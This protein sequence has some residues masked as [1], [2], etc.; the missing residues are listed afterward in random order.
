MEYRTKTN[1]KKISNEESQVA[2]KHLKK[3]SSSLIIGKMQIKTSLR[4]YLTIV[5]MAKIENSGHRRCW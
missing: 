4:F 5:I 1:K 3:C 2:E